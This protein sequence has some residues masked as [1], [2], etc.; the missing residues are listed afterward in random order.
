MTIQRPFA[1]NLIYGGWTPVKPK[2]PV[3]VYLM[4]SPEA[5]TSWTTAWVSAEGDVWPCDCQSTLPYNP[6]ELAQAMWMVIPEPEML[7]NVHGWYVTN[8]NFIHE[9]ARLEGPMP[10]ELAQQVTKARL[11]LAKQCKGE[12]PPEEPMKIAIMTVGQ[13]RK[14]LLDISDDAVLLCPSSD[15]EYKP[16]MVDATTALYDAKSR[17]WTEDHGEAVTPEKDYG[18]RQPV[19]VF[20]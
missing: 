7:I 10:R 13:L 9:L 11:M 16:A 4:K 14:Q 19:L 20:S 5:S 6:T 8:V 12:V 3:N 15:H 17:T 18:K 1:H 2:G